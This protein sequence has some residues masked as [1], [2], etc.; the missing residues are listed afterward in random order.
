M[1][2]ITSQKLSNRLTQYGTLSLAIA[3][4]N[5]A[6]GQIVHNDIPDYNGVSSDPR[7]EFIIDL[8]GD[9]TDDFNIVGGT[10]SSGAYGYV[11]VYPITTSAASF[12]GSMPGSFAYPL[13]MSFNDTISSGQS[14]WFGA[15]FGTMNFASCF[16]GGGAS[17][18][19][20]VT[21]RYL[22]LRVNIANG[23]GTLDDE[24]FYG[25]VRL[26]V[27]LDAFSFVIKE[28]AYNSTS[29]DP[30][31]AGQTTLGIEDNV[32]SQVKVVALNKSIGLYNLQDT[33]RYSVINMTGQQVLKGETQNRDYVIEAPTLASGVYIVELNDSK[34][35]TVMRKKVVLQ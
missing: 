1:K 30:I 15:N 25:W 20:G 4:I 24:V 32:L 27:S 2:K 28:Y 6:S 21:D 9:L 19:C 10:V 35:D 17:N 18:W 26:D 7:D 8:N 12:L 34:S 11:G 3:G 22:G 29:G 31:T 5:S 16:L 33:S 23:P 14:Q 13:A